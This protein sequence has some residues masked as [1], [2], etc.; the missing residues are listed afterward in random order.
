M[1]DPDRGIDKNRA[2]RSD[3]LAGVGERTLVGVRSL[4]KERG[5]LHFPARSTL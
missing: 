4:P 1:I 3:G 2:A 5:V